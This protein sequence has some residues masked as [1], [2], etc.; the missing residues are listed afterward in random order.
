MKHRNG[1][2]SG[3]LIIVSLALFPI[4]TLHPSC[5]LRSVPIPTLHPTCPLR[6]PQCCLTHIGEVVSD[7]LK[8]KI[9]DTE[10]WQQKNPEVTH[11]LHS[12]PQP[13]SELLRNKMNY[14][15]LTRHTN[16]K[17]ETG[18]AEKDYL[19]EPHVLPDHKL[20]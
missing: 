3:P 18:A 6:P 4:P 12:A 8:K 14:N 10:A 1:T 17:S 19:L 11:R 13:R 7:H 15:A 2:N 5:P 20:T 9:P 16:L